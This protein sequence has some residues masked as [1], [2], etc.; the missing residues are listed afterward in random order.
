M[1]TSTFKKF[2]GLLPGN[3]LV[4]AT[5]ATHNA[6]GTSTLTTLDGGTMRA[7]GQVVP[8]AGLA[9]VRAGAVE[10]PAPVLPAFK[11]TV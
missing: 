8:V 5:V 6:D 1:T 9:F 11:L 7:R 10:G 2:R 4:I 3:S